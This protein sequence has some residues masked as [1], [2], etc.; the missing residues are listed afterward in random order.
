MLI[1]NAAEK[2]FDQNRNISWIQLQ[3]LGFKILIKSSHSLF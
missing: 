3:S 1:K 2:T